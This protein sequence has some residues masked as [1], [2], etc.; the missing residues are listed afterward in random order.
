MHAVL[1]AL[2][3]IIY[4]I[5]GAVVIVATLRRTTEMDAATRRA[6]I[7]RA[8]TVLLIPVLV[9]PILAGGISG[10]N[11]LPFLITEFVLAAAVLTAAAVTVRKATAD[12]PD[13]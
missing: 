3:V 12:R 7:W 9:G 8:Y 4:V 13:R 5:V 6:E 1:Y 10:G 11:F 2:P